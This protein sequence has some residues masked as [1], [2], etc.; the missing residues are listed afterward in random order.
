MLPRLRNRNGSRKMSWKFRELY[1]IRNTPFSPSWRNPGKNSNAQ[2]Y[3]EKAE[4]IDEILRMREGA[5]NL[6]LENFPG[7]YNVASFQGDNR[8]DDIKDT[9]VSEFKKMKGVDRFFCNQCDYSGIRARN[10]QEHCVKQHGKEAKHDYKDKIGDWAMDDVEELLKYCFG[11]LEWGLKWMPPQWKEAHPEAM[12][13]KMQRRIAEVEAGKKQGAPGT[14]EESDA[15]ETDSIVD[16]ALEE[17]RIRC[18]I[19]EGSVSTSPELLLDHFCQEYEEKFHK[20]RF[21][22]TLCDEKRSVKTMYKHCGEKHGDPS[23]YIEG[24]CVLLCGGK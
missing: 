2:L 16:D 14:K 4:D 11:D 24:V 7:K 23:A 10:V 15:K 9:F 1:S 13:M 21:T 6:P 18:L 8:T 19:C 20:S 12:E 22:C 17:G 3:R 5:R